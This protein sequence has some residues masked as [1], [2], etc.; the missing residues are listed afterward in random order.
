M[1]KKKWGEPVEVKQVQESR[2]KNTKQVGVALSCIK[3]KPM[4]LGAK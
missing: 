4:F 1:R 3:E 2:N